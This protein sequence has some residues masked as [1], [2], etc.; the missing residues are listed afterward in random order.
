MP[1]LL[2]RIRNQNFHAKIVEPEAT[3]PLFRDGMYLGFSGFAGGNPKVIPMVLADYVE[4]NNL[5]GKIG[6]A[7]V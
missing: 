3:I 1:E 5:Q 4:K 6:R 2:K 7:H